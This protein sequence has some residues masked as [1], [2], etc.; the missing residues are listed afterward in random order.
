MRIEAEKVVAASPAEVFGFLQR[1]ENHWLVTDEFVDLLSLDSEGAGPASDGGSVRIRG[2]LGIHRTALTRV[3]HAEPPC[4]LRGTADVGRGT[5][6]EVSWRLQPLSGQTRVVLSATVLRTGVL[7]RLALWLGGRLW[8]RR[9]FAATLEH[10]A[11]RL[12]T[13]S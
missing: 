13:G 1:L 10:L 8:L 12:A 2:P 4:L 5:R 3:V 6:A 9:R 7:D 11:G